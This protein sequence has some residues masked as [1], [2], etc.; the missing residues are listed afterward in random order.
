MPFQLVMPDLGPAYCPTRRSSVEW[1][2]AALR[3][4]MHDTYILRSSRDGEMYTGTTSDLRSRLTLHENGRIPSTALRR[5]LT[6]V[7]HEACRSV[8]DPFR[9]ERY[10]RTGKAKRYIRNR[11]A[12][13]LSASC[14]DQLERH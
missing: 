7:Y 9:R 4:A 11:L 8:D 12:S 2:R 3:T 1:D 14:P 13:F 6:L 10:L 5:P